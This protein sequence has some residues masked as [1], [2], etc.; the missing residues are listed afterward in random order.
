MLAV[1]HARQ[2]FPSL[3]HSVSHAAC[4]CCM[5]LL[6]ASMRASSACHLVKCKATQ[7]KSPLQHE[8]LPLSPPSVGK[9]RLAAAPSTW[10]SQGEMLAVPVCGTFDTFLLTR[11]A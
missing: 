5:I 4:S 3:G 1:L 10:T 2:H 7:A 6:A 11:V 8:S 9:L